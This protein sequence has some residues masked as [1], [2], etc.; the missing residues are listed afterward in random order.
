MHRVARD[1]TRASLLAALAALGAGCA[2]KADAE[3]KAT[4]PPTPVQ[5]VVAREGTIHPSLEIAGVITPYRQVGVTANLSEPLTDVEVV[6][7]QHVTKGQLLARQLTDDLQA[8]LLSSERVVRED[9]ARLAQTLYTTTATTAQNTTSVSSAQASLHEAQ[10]NLS[11]AETDYK[12]YLALAAQGYLPAQ[13]LDQQ[14]VVVATDR[15]ALAAA[16]ATLASAQANN[17][18]NGNGNTAGAQQQD[19]QAAQDAVDAA[20]ATVDQLKAQIAR[21]VIVAPIDGIVDSVNANPGEYPS[22]RQLFTIEQTA[23]VYAVLPSSTAQVLGIR[24]GAAASIETNTSYA[25]NPHP[26]KDHGTVEAVLDQIQP[27]TTNFSVK[28][29]VPNPDGHLRAGMPVNGFVDLPPVHGI[30]VPITAFIDDTHTT[31]YTV[32]DDIVHQRTVDDIAEDGANAV[33]TGISP[34]ERVIESVTATTVGN[35]DKVNPSPTPAPAPSGKGSPA[36]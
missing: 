19:I 32:D 7:G 2:S 33:V 27:G 20:Q 26:H 16:Q 14:R 34:N 5:T 9:S 24:T 6:E 11:G 28:V 36:P 13:T 21:A 29:L 3:A 4:P 17:A 25:A 12:R 35:G 8:Q 22:G 15:Q 31:L 30:V 18:A 10:V 1:A 23:S